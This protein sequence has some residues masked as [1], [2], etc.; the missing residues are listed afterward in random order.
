MADPVVLPPGDK[1]NKHDRKA[2]NPPGAP[3]NPNSSS[4]G[5]GGGGGGG[6]SSAEKRAV[7]RE[8]AAK[9]K[10]GKRYLESAANLE[11]QAKALRH[12]LKID[13]A[14]ARNNN[15]ADVSLVL[16]QNL[17]ALKA[18]AALR[19]AD[20]L[21]TASDTQK[22]TADTAEAG[23]SN[24]IRER[25][26]TLTGILTQGAGETDT[27]RAM[28][29]SAR[30]WQENASENNR[31]Y[32]DSIRSINSGITDLNVDTKN[33]LIE[34]NTNAEAERDRIWQNFYDRRSETF[35]Q[36]GNVKGQQ[37]DYYAQAKE[38]GAKPKKGVEKASEKAMKNAF[39]DA[40]LEAGKSY[41]QK[42][43]PKWISDYKGTEQVKAAQS[44]SNLAA[45][46]VLD[47]VEKAEGAT[48]RK[49]A[50]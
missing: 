19:G 8:N 12:A 4:G 29:M 41:T 2:G 22:A 18:G 7:A 16:S 27:L 21:G 36:L 44:N 20:L 37:A 10:A 26:D 42:A 32:F 24:A 47:P 15:L 14:K 25:Q 39:M 43:L 46:M 38:M 45:A 23:V 5:G 9:K 31:T 28:V 3:K 33:A 1:T 6:A 49:W 34:S 35:T 48:L 13:F 30:N 40:A 50:A 11:L 17:S